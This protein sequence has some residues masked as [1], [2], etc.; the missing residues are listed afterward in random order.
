MTTFFFAIALATLSLCFCVALF[1]LIKVK[2]GEKKLQEFRD[3]VFRGDSLL[4]EAYEAKEQEFTR[5]EAEEYSRK[6]YKLKARELMKPIIDR[7][8][9]L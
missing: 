3:I 9:E 5:Q 7:A 1:F 2:R 8:N 6:D 4:H